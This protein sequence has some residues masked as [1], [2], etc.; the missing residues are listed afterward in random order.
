VVGVVVIVAIAFATFAALGW[1]AAAGL[2]DGDQPG[3]A[4]VSA[5][6][7]ESGQPDEPRPVVIATVRN[8]SDKPVLAGLSARRTVVPG[9][10]RCG[11]SVTVPTRTA[12]RSLRPT[13]YATIGVV[14]PH[15]SARFPVAIRGQLARRYLLTAAIGQAGG[16]LRLHRL[17]VA[18]PHSAAATELTLPFGE[19]LFD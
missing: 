14:P 10:L 15:A 3:D 16:R 19:D 11:P 18:G 1:R 2:R 8:P 17:H 13:A 4:K 12:R 6:L 7:R 9:L 5:L